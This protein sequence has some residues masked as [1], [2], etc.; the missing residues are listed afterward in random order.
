MTDEGFTLRKYGNLELSSAGLAGGGQFDDNSLIFVVH[1]DRLLE[2]IQ[3]RDV[4]N[5]NVLTEALIAGFGQFVRNSIPELLI[6]GEVSAFSADLDEQL[7]KLLGEND[8]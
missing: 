4:E 8:T 5:L 2:A 6:Q 3:G 1:T 7:K